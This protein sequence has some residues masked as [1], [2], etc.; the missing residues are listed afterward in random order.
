[1]HFSLIAILDPPSSPAGLRDHLAKALE[2]FR[3][4][5]SDIETQH[6][7]WDCFY[8]ARHKMEEN[9]RQEADGRFGT[10]VKLADRFKSSGPARPE[11][12]TLADSESDA[13]SKW[14][15]YENWAG[16]WKHFVQKRLDW[17]QRRTAELVAGLK[18][19]PRCQQCHGTGVVLTGVQFRKWD[20]WFTAV[21]ERSLR[22]MWQKATQLRP[23]IAAQFSLDLAK[24]SGDFEDE[25]VS[26][27]IMHYLAAHEKASIPYAVL[28]SDGTWHEQQ[29]GI[30]GIAHLHPKNQGLVI[31]AEDEFWPL[32]FRSIIEEKVKDDDV[33]IDID[34]H[35]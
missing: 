3:D 8:H 17:E 4:V 25:A 15:D 6:E 28:T 31:Y 20:Y 2:P 10:A 21:E 11:L 22:E 18:A 23:Q 27:R 5:E 13:A 9:A 33:C 35:T 30:W 12:P 34:C 19:D 14:R 16:T 29:P 7:C 32:R 24:L 1:M 26:G